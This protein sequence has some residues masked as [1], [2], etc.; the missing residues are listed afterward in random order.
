MEKLPDAHG[1]NHYHKVFKWLLPKF[2]E[3]G[4]YKFV[5]AQ[6]RNYMIQ[7][8]QKRAYKPS[9]FDPIDEKYITADHVA[10][11]FW[12]QLVHVRKGLAS[13]GDCWS[14]HKLLDAIGIAKES[15]PCN[16]F[17]DMM[18]CMHFVNDWEDEEGD[19]WDDTLMGM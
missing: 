10:R 19:E 15:M 11:F 7:I 2:G 17:Y 4:F 3:D 1:T 5:A 9:Y 8:I 14:T 6:M 16:A 18:R 12:C 13:V